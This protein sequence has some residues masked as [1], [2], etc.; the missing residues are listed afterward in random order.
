MIF[1]NC[2]TKKAIRIINNNIIDSKLLCLISMSH[3][4]NLYKHNYILKCYDLLKI[5]K[6]YIYSI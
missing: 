1:I 3:T 6:K 2:N 5:Y 4:N